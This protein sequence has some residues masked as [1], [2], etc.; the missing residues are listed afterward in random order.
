[1]RKRIQPRVFYGWWM[2]AACLLSTGVGNALGLFG[3]GVYLHAV[4]ETNAWATGVVS[5]AVTLFYVVSAVLLIPVGSGIARFGARPFVS[6]GALAMAMGVAG[7]GRAWE[8]WQVYLAFPIMGIG[9][10]CLS[11]TSVATTLAPWFETYQGR[12]ISIAS[13]GASAGGMMGPPL[14]L[15]GIGGLGFAATATLAACCAVIIVLPIALVVL[16]HRPED[17]GL[18]PDGLPATR[19]A[20]QRQ[21]HVWNRA[22]ALRT[23]ELQTT[24]MAFGIGMAMQIGF[25]THQVTFLAQSLPTWAVAV[26]ISATAVAGLTGRLAL[27]RF[28]DRIDARMTTSVVLVLAALSF[29][30]MALLTDPYILACG[31]VVFGLTVG[32]V[33]TLSPIVVRREFGADAFGRVFGLASCVIQLVTA[34]GPGFYGLLHDHFGGYRQPLLVAAMLDGMAAW[35]ILV[36]RNKKR[37]SDAVQAS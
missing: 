2:V 12:A 14:L 7:V 24:M 36:G 18:T 25:L 8:P 11:T 30:V 34:L 10:A 31:C 32:N 23:P 28:A 17:M 20:S 1:M 37:A 5:G 21:T 15:M 4:T 22:A 33:T 29:C 6:L 35:I 27:A 9:W 26:T 16:R 19:G 13:L 3:A